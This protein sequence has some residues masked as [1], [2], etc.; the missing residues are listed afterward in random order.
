MDNDKEANKTGVAGKRSSSKPGDSQKDATQRSIEANLTT[1]GLAK[2]LNKVEHAKEGSREDPSLKTKMIKKRQVNFEQITP[3]EPNHDKD[4]QANRQASRYR[5]GGLGGLGNLINQISSGNYGG[6]GDCE[7]PFNKNY[8][9]GEGSAN[10]DDTDIDH[11]KNILLNERIKSIVLNPVTKNFIEEEEIIAQGGFDQLGLQSSA[12]SPSNLREPGGLQK[13]FTFN[14]KGGGVKQKQDN[15]GF[16][17]VFDISKGIDLGI[18]GKKSKQKKTK[19]KNTKV[20]SKRGEALKTHLRQYLSIVTYLSIKFDI[21]ESRFDLIEILQ[22]SKDMENFDP[23]NMLKNMRFIHDLIGATLFLSELA[24]FVMVMKDMSDMYMLISPRFSQMFVENNRYD[25]LNYWFYIFKDFVV[26]KPPS[27]EFVNSII[28]DDPNEDDKAREQVMTDGE[29]SQIA[30]SVQPGLT[31]ARLQELI[32]MYFQSSDENQMI[33]NLFNAMKLPKKVIVYL[34]L[35]SKEEERLI[36][37][38][39]DYDG[40][41]ELLSEQDILKR[42]QYKLFILFDSMNLINIFNLDIPK[43]EKMEVPIMMSKS[44][45]LAKKSTIQDKSVSVYKEL[46]HLI[47]RGENVESLCNVVNYV[48]ETFWDWPKAQRF[49][50]SIHG[51]LYNNGTSWLVYIQ[52]PLQFFMTLAN[53]FKEL[54]EQLDYKDKKLTELSDDMMNFCLNYIEHASDQVLKLNMFEKDGKDLCFLD[55]AFMVG[56]MNILEKEQ[57][58]G[59]LELLWDQGR[60][61]LQTL[62]QFMRVDI[63]IYEVHKKFT[64]GIFKHNFDIEIE[65]NDSFQLEYAYTFNSVFLKVL[66]EIIWPIPLIFFEFAYSESTI[67]S[68][69]S[70]TLTKDYITDYLGNNLLMAS[71]HGFLRVSFLI[72]CVLKSMTLKGLSD[73]PNFIIVFYNL[74][75]ALNFIQVIIIPL[76]FDTSF[77][78]GCN[79]QML[80]V[81]VLVTYCLYNALALEIGVILRIF[82]RMA[83][84]VLFFGIASYPVIAIVAYPIHTVFLHFSQ[85]IDGEPFPDL[86]VFS[87]LYQGIMVCYEFA[88]GAVVLVRPFIEQTTDSYTMTFVM[89]LFAFFGNIML[90]NLLIAFLTSQFDQINSNAKYLTMNMQWGL[91]KVFGIK[92]L[93]TIFSMPYPLV[94]PALPFYAFMMSREKRKSVNHFLSKIIHFVNIFLPVFIFMNIKLLFLMMWRYITIF[95]HLLTRIPIRPMNSL[96]SLVW[97]PGGIYLFVK[98][99]LKDNYTLLKVL[100][101]FDIR[102]KDMPN[103]L[104][105]DDA[106]NELVSIFKKINNAVMH[107][108]NRMNIKRVTI[109]QLIQDIETLEITRTLTQVV[110]TG[111]VGPHHPETGNKYLEGER[112]LTED[113]GHIQDIDEFYLQS[114]HLLLPIILKKYAII[115]EGQEPILDMEFMRDKLKNRMNVENVDKL[116]AFEKSTLDRASRYFVQENNY[117]VDMGVNEVKI[118]A[119]NMDEKLKKM[120][121]IVTCMRSK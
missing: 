12:K 5:T 119:D 15:T 47:E 60:H 66:A 58:E 102:G 83:L 55:Y 62:D 86:N 91:I 72:S 23:Q 106:R 44:E 21:N 92:D 87:S 49:F 121:D 117:T 69:M 114:E 97:I 48:S 7:S 82:F 41:I 16:E 14:A 17:L 74:V 89:M 65:D 115:E 64:M 56:K 52:N 118:F 29:D 108:L 57:I 109:R 54:R 30:E 99:Y 28:M 110:D 42:K 22:K 20:T 104:L 105:G 43:E 90:A 63:M 77:W 46:C 27:K 37:V 67:L 53:F 25:Y 85:A 100:L 59:T 1:G 71:I 79:A 6:N 93:D 2:K 116:I 80:Y 3:P 33:M 120:M 61:T 111:I 26:A 32:K 75:I 38:A 19:Q 8:G 35:E 103:Y 101:N 107:N 76:F 45:L 11:I 73:K 4:R 68:Y 94:I 18:L 81:F 9:T 40:I 113:I 13:K 50:I 24:F 36:R 96:Y 112:T 31:K 98:L 88:F 39:N 34:L 95:L 70:G 51:L 78:W 10:L 84:V